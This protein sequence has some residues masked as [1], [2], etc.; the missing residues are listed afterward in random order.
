MPS[1]YLYVPTRG[2][3]NMQLTL[4]NMPAKWR[5]RTKIVCPKSE[6]REHV[7]N[8]PD[9]AAI[10]HQPDPD[11]SIAQKRKWIF[12]DAAKRGIEKIMMLDD[13]L[14]F[15]PRHEIVPSFAGFQKKSHARDWR[16]HLQKDPEASG[17][18]KSSDPEDQKIDLAFRKVEAALDRYRHGGLGPR[19][20]NNAFGCEFSLNKRCMYAIAFHTPTVLKYCTLGR[21]EHREDFDLTLQLMKKGFENFRYEMCVVE[22]YEGYNA[23]GGASDERSMK[24]S[25]ADAYKL[26]RLHPG[27]VKVKEK[28]YL[29]S[30]PRVEVVVRW[31]NAAELGKTG[32]IG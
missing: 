31:Q 11:M 29:V 16:E 3:V 10:V 21:I 19:L 28:D 30:T 26:A 15:C 27:F 23:A 1:L 17:L 5:A 14:S 8:W 6:A 4:K 12:E 24:A 32:L 9:V 22:Q 2:R 25:N 7:K 13:D 20:M 18:Y